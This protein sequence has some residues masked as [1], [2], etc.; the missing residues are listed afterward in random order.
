MPS[1]IST[2]HQIVSRKLLECARVLASLFPMVLQLKAMRG[3]IAL[4]KRLAQNLCEI[5]F[6]SSPVLTF[7]SSPC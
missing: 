4:P 3:R 6:I 7:A 5:V 2:R 1:M